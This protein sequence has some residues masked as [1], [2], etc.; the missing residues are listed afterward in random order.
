MTKFSDLA[1]DPR[2]LQAV[3]EAGYETR[4]GV[5]FQVHEVVGAVDAQLLDPV[6]MDHWR[7][8]VGHGVAHD[9]GAAGAGG[10]VGVSLKRGNQSGENEVDLRMRDSCVRCAPISAL[11]RR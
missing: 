1:L 6:T 2:V 7:T 11:R 9:A 3:A 4:E 8:G 10:H 5:G